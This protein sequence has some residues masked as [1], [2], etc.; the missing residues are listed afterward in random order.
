[1]S[2]FHRLKSGPPAPVKAKG[3][4]HQLVADAAKAMAREVYQT[5]ARDNDWYK[6]WPSEDEF[7]RK[8]W[9]TFIQNAREHLAEALQPHFLLSE[10]EKQQIYDALLLNAASNPAAN[11]IDD[12][13]DG[14]VH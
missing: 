6:L 13:I 1:M 12:V 3:A 2:R 7:T 10:A 4:V 11:A 14:R 9:Q 8:R 5:M